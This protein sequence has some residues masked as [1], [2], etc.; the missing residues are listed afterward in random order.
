MSLISGSRVSNAFQFS[1]LVW[2]LFAADIADSEICFAAR[3]N[4]FYVH[5]G[6]TWSGILRST[7]QKSE[8]EVIEVKW[9][10][11][12]HY[13]SAGSRPKVKLSLK[14]FTVAAP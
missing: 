5:T 9:H 14:S 7:K 2:Q 11:N 1:L 8:L 10:Q 12:S 13:R 6:D 3:C 4:D